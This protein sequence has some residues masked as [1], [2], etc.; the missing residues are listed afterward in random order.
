MIKSRLCQLIYR[1]IYLGL[2][3]FGILESFGLLAGQKPSLECMI[4]YTSLSNFLCFGIMIALVYTTAK[5]IKYNK[6]YGESNNVGKL[7][8]YSSIAIFVTFIVYNFIL[9]DNMFSEGWNNLGNLTKHII[10]PLMFVIDGILFDEHHKLTVLDPLKCTILPLIY[11]AFILIR[12]A[13][14]NPETYQGTIY[15]YFFLD[16][17]NLGYF[18]VFKWVLILVIVF[19]IIAYLFFFYDKFEKEEGKFSF[20]LG[21]IKNN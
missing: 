11:V 6:L 3:F 1:C 2:A 16:V 8:F 13:F 14:L 9:V 5:H 15:P 19:I 18:G 10:C 4:W 20:D 7:K 21:S 17:N 12:G